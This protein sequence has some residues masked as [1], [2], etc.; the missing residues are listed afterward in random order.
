MLSQLVDINVQHHVHIM[1]QDLTDIV[2][3]QEVIV[4]V[5]INIITTLTI[6]HNVYLHVQLIINL[7]QIVI[8]VLVHVHQDM[9]SQYQD[10]I[11]QI[12]VLIV[13]Q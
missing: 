11:V 9:Q 4:L 7:I 8:N 12:H 3:N 13:Y 2:F 5:L 10:I 6:H 1:F